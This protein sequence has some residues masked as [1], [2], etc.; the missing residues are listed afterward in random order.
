VKKKAFW[1]RRDFMKICGC[2]LA[3]LA[4]PSCSGSSNNDV[5]ST[6][7]DEKKLINEFSSWIDSCGYVIKDKLGDSKGG[8]I[9]NEC[10]SRFRF[11]IPQIPWI[12]GDENSNTFFLM[13]GA[14]SMGLIRPLERAGLSEREIGHVIY[15]MSAC[16]FELD[17]EKMEQQGQWMVT[18]EAVEYMR[19]GALWSQ[20]KTYPDDFVFAFVEPGDNMYYGINMTE[21]GILKFYREQSLE[22]YVKYNCLNDYP[23]YQTYNIHLGRTQTLGNGAACCNF[24]YLKTGTTQDG[25]PPETKP[26]FKEDA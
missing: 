1:S 12:G 8:M 18:P 15:L 16:S 10:I 23:M 14:Y 2:A 22:K 24:M 9:I 25:W 21:C 20:K 3:S 7:Y 13:G 6:P 26:E 17:K 19:Q 11:I 5:P 4:L